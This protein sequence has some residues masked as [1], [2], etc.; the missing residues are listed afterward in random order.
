MRPWCYWLGVFP[1]GEVGLWTASATNN[2]QVRTTVSAYGYPF[3]VGVAAH[4][5]CLWS[6]PVMVIW[7][8]R[9]ATAGPRTAANGLTF[10]VMSIDR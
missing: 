8:N 9:L 5:D 6:G 1:K 3:A 7:V 4:A 10:V 2:L